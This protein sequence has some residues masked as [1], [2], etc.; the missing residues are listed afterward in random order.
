MLVS[1]SF[2]I[3][4]VQMVFWIEG[5]FFLL[6]FSFLFLSHSGVIFIAKQKKFRR[7]L[8]VKKNI[9][10]LLPFGYL[11]ICLFSSMAWFCILYSINYLILWC[12]FFSPIFGFT[13]LLLFWMVLVIL[14]AFRERLK[15][16]HHKCISEE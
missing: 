3:Q 16:W 6:I 2:C 10:E 5:F 1:L 15:K 12:I 4:M 13:L 8:D 7:L 9:Y 11:F 14:Q